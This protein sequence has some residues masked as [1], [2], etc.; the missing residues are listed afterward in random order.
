MRLRVAAAVASLTLVVAAVAAASVAQAASGST[1]WPHSAAQM[2]AFVASVGGM[3]ATPEWQ[4]A[5]ARGVGGKVPSTRRSAPAA[6]PARVTGPAL[7]YVSAPPYGAVVEQ[8]L[9]GG[10][11]VTLVLQGD[12]FS[13]MWQPKVSPDGTQL[14]YLATGVNLGFPCSPPMSL[15]VLDLGT[16]STRTVVTGAADMNLGLPNWRPDGSTLL[17]TQ[18][19]VDGSSSQLFTVPATGGVSVPVPGGGVGGFDGVYSPDG[20]KIAFGPFR[21]TGLSVMNA[22]GSGVVPLTQTQSLSPD[23]FPA[24][25]PSW[26][27]DGTRIALTY[28]KGMYTTP[29]HYGPFIVF[30]IAVVDA[31]NTTATKLPVTSAVVPPKATTDAE[32][33]WSSDGSE[34]FYSENQA[35]DFTGAS[36]Y[37]TNATGTYRTTVEGGPGS[38]G[39]STPQFVGPVPGVGSASSYTPVTP[40]RL[41]LSPLVLGPGQTTDVQVTGP[42][43]PVPAGATAVTVNLTGVG[44][45]AATDLRVYPTP[46]D[47]SVP[48]VSNLNLTAGMTAAVAVQASVGTGGMVRI[49]NNAGTVSVLV[50]ESG[51]FVPGGGANGYYPVTPTRVLD[52]GPAGLGSGRVADVNLTQY[53]A[54]I[55]GLTPV[56]A[57]LNLAGDK[58]SAATDLRVYPTPGDG[59]VPTVSNLNLPTGGTRANLVTV[60]IGLGGDVRVFNHTGTVRAV[61][62]LLGFYGRGASGGMVYYPLDPARVLDTRDGTNTRL[63]STAPV[64]AAGSIMLPLRGTTTTSAGIITVPAAAQ[65]FVYTLTAVDP[66]WSTGTFLT[67]YATGGVVPA[68]STLNAA[69]GTVVPNLAITTAGLG[70]AIDIFNAHGSTAVVADLAG[71]YAP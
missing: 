68:T 45:S 50:D 2:R 64:A 12:G 10:A 16:G 52:T 17:Y 7:V 41:T 5:A 37:A 43:T 53:A 69:G 31:A 60:A 48:T 44:A 18:G 6:L 9:R 57:V 23:H 34:I 35:P 61:V 67:A 59:S 56:A 71:Y 32:P 25:S 62:D 70:G 54:G 28:E 51:Y 22:D 4:R 1:S 63:G 13:C 19:A 29:V 8:S 66:T 21:G 27:P 36:I 11:P 38:V 3:S 40:T 46:S 30:G 14:A 26:S 65:A 49:R 15:N 58:A 55:S 47:G 20:T 42:G 24:S 33:A 39:A